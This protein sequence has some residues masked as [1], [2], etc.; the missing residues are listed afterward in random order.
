M[1]AIPDAVARS[2]RLLPAAYALHVAEEAPGFAG[3]VRRHAAADYTQGEFVRIN[4]LG[5]AGTVLAGALA[6]RGGAGAH[7]AYYTAILT[8]QALW[9][10]VFHA[11]TTLAWREYSPGLATS[12][13]LF[14]PL[15]MSATRGALRSGAL[16][17]RQVGVGIVV[18]GVMHAAT[19]ASTVFHRPRN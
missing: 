4:A 1:D 9:N 13:A 14:V 16:T 6:D 18:G 2:A 10:P 8:A 11:A 12:L 19:V 17:R 7:A 5:F 3:W 15:W